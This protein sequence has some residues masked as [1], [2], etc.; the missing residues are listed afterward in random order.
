L[1]QSILKLVITKGVDVV[2]VVHLGRGPN[3]AQ[4]IALLWSQPRCMVEDCGRIFR[5]ECDHGVPWADNH[6]T[7]LANIRRLCDHHHD[8]KTYFGWDLVEGEGPRP[9]VPPDH[10]DHPRNKRRRE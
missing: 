1:G 10:P 6:A 5:L 8:L 7:V 4:K 2:N 3:T 9:M